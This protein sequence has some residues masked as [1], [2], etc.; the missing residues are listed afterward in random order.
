VVDE[1]GD[2][3]LPAGWVTGLLRVGVVLTG[4]VAVI[5][6]VEPVLPKDQGLL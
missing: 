3:L 4:V 5:R 6:R 1:L 2:E